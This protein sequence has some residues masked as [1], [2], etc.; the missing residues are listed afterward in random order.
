MIG[1]GLKK[2]AA[3]HGLKIQK[4]VA[5]GSLQGYAAT[6]SEGSGWKQIVFATSFADPVQKTAFN[7]AVSGVNLLKT[8]RV[9]HMN[10]TP[11]SIQVV[12]NDTVGTMKKINEFIQWFL[13]LLRQYGASAWN[14]CAECG[15]EVTGGKW[16]LIEGAAYYMHESCAQKVIRDTVEDDQRRAQEDTGTYLK[17]A[18]GA[19][20]GAGLGAV[21]WALV[22]LL[23]YVASIVGLLIG[24]L[25]DRGYRLMHGKNGK[26]KVAILIGSIIFGVVIGTIGADV[27]TLVKMIA[28][29]ELPSVAYGDIPALMLVLFA[30]DAEY[31][32]IMLK[33]IGMGL[34]FAA[35][36]VY[37]FVFRTGKEVA[38]TKIVELN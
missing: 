19:F 12:F 4:G 26:G 9:R 33:N 38:G 2:L 18:L 31:R 20:V 8:Y 24:W 7:D 21:V 6:M 14:A 15:C 32:A 25:S 35:L 1:S 29:G 13:P 30:E 16:M 37:Y 22:L 28:A 5:Y 23:G 36:G 11:N 10:V 3:E 27:I 34:L 17:G